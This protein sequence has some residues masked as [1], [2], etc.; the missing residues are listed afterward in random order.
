MRATGSAVLAAGVIVATSAASQVLPQTAAPPL[1]IDVVAVTSDGSPVRDLRPE[2]VTVRLDGN[3]RTVRSLQ[4]VAGSDA[5]GPPS[6]AAMLAPPY[7]TNAIP[8]GARSILLV[9][10]DESLRS[11]DD[12]RLKQAIAEMLTSLRATDRVAL[13]TVP[14]GGVRVDFT[15]DRDRL[16][17]AS[18]AIGA[19][20]AA[21]SVQDTLCHTR[22]VLDQLASTIDGVNGNPSPTI[23]VLMT[24]DLAGPRSDAGRAGQP[25]G[26]CDV[27]QENFRAATRAFAGVR[28]SFYLVQI[29]HAGGVAGDAMSRGGAVSASGIEHLADVMGA[30]TLGLARDNALNRIAKETAA[31]YQLTFDAGAA[32]R[33]GSLHRLD[34]SSTRAGLTVRAQPGV[35]RRTV[36]ST[37]RFVARTPVETLRDTNAYRD[38]PIRTTSVVSRRLADPNHRLM[39]IAMAEPIDAGTRIVSAAAALYDQTGKQA[40]AWVSRPEDLITPP[41]RGGLL[42]APGTYRLRI[43]AADAAGHLGAVDSEVT[44]QLTTAGPLSMSSLAIG[45]SDASGDFKPRFEL[46][47]SDSTAAAFFEL[48]GGRTNMQLGAAVEV[49]AAAGG[50]ALVSA[51]P[52]WNSTSEPDRFTATTQLPIASLP[53]GDYVVR[54]I[55]GVEGQPEGRI[56]RTLR[57]TP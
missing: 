37:L 28:A 22:S 18:T 15:A 2:E 9:I 14:Q 16:T 23:L 46:G 47:P 56:L 45:V 39:V 17:R 53:P 54:A 6:S 19:R 24:A 29:E 25:A 43:A 12:A 31:S 49:A 7:E 20:A 26:A 57:K 5:P 38:L 44:V 34:V 1:T 32:D 27:T 42:V 10:D 13:A 35:T 30:Q 3:A 55:L 51:K 11:G 40:A 50:P 52:R 48:Y 21:S 36:T 41:V 4:L 8:P 33:N